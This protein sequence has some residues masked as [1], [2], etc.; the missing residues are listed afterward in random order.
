MPTDILATHQPEF[1]KV[2]DY[3]KND[4]SQL[5]TGRATPAL[6]ENVTVEAYGAKQALVGLASITTPDAR[7]ILVEP[8]DKS[9]L[10]DIEKAILE[11][12]LGLNPVV[13]GQQIRITLPA[14]TEEGRKNLI[15]VLNEKLE[16]ARIGVRKVRDEAKADIVKA[17]KD[18]EIGEDEK[19][20]LLEQLD[21][22]AAG[23][24]E[25]I[26]NIGEEKETEIMTI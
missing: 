24:N 2:I 13:Q 6:V 21:K 17:E 10:K 7:N 14:L 4:I 5:R 8:W 19:Y 22:A 1:Q 16:N 20:K 23:W 11:T 25:R 12:K 18:K 3:L 15:K 9:V 26:K